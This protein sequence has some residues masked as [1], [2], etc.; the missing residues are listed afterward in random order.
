MADPK[1]LPAPPKAKH[2][3]EVLERR[4]QNPRGQGAPAIALTLGGMVPRW[5]NGA[6][7]ADKIWRAKQDG[8]EPVT[9]DLLADKEQIG[10]F[11]TSPDGYV[12]RGERQQE[13]LMYQPLEWRTKIQAAKTRQNNKDLNTRVPVLEAAGKQ[14][15]DQAAT[16]MDGQSKAVGAVRDNYERIEVTPEA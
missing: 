13:V 15:G 5:F 11:Q 3:I 4:L 14:L 10:G 9:P 6:I 8:W 16:L 1:P 2:R 7:S 12:T